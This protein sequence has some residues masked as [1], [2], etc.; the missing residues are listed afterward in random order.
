[1]SEVTLLIRLSMSPS[2]SF[3]RLLRKPPLPS[4]VL[5]RVV[6]PRRE[7]LRV[8]SSALGRKDLFVPANRQRRVRINA[9]REQAKG[10]RAERR[11][12][13]YLRVQ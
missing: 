3:M 8:R 11:M 12:A 7:A 6:C 9:A 13:E 10:N 1:M 5:K 2:T 4:V